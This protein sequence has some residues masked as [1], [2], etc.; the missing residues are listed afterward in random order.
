MVE[1][2]RIRA[3]SVLADSIGMSI[4][5]QEDDEMALSELER[6]LALRLSASRIFRHIEKL[7]DFGP[8]PLGSPGHEK[9]I[10]YFEEELKSY[11][12]DFE[13]ADF[14]IA[15]SY[16][17]KAELKLISPEQ[18][19]IECLANYRSAASPGGGLKADN[20]IDVGHGTEKE[21]DGKN[22]SGAIVL[23]TEGSGHPVTKSELA[24]EKGAAGCVWINRQRGRR[25]STYGLARYGSKIPIVSISYEDGEFLRRQLSRNPI[26]LVL[27]VDTDL[28]ISTGEHVI[29]IVSGQKRPEEIIILCAHYETVPG[30]PGANDN[31]SGVAIVLEVLKVFASYQPSRTIWALLS[32]GEEG[33]AI[34]MRAFVDGNKAKMKSVKAVLNADVLGEGTKLV[35]YKEGRWPNRTVQASDALN[36]IVSEAAGDLGYHLVPA[37]SAMGL[38]DT[39]AFI[40][41]GIPGA[42]IGRR[43]WHYNHTAEDV[44]ETIDVNGL[45]VAADI[46]TVASLRLDKSVSLDSL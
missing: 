26:T 3:E 46:L 27:R 35:I 12:A 38:A 7:C 37:V 23:A 1:R 13:T 33:G 10:Q 36:R 39:E 19:T 18:R 22:V 32:T 34:G 16:S 30:S 6:E 20:V 24:A 29:G 43:G 8:R 40:E 25:I 14:E 28:G 42:W 5:H 15:V 21:Y 11:G 4:V 44:P 17:T 9:S 41:A 2:Y 45:K 31:A